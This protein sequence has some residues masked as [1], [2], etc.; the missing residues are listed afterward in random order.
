MK[1]VARQLN[2]NKED[3]DMRWDPLEGR[4]RCMEHA[5]HLSAGHFIRTVSPTSARALA[6]KI[7]KAFRD[8]EL[9]DD[10]IL[11]ADLENDDDDDNDDNDDNDDDGDNA[12]SEAG[13]FTVGD[14]IGKSLALV[15][16]V[17]VRMQIIMR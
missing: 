7:K 9:G 5:V 15:K 1:E 6:K 17:S 16:Q 14:T 12:A 10:A 4:I 8:G 11:V 3:D 13:N 2:A